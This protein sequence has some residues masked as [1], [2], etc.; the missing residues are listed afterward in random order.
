MEC[1]VLLCDV[2]CLFCVQKLKA[3]HEL[4][5]YLNAVVK[6]SRILAHDENCAGSQNEI[7]MCEEKYVL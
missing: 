6:E 4:L 1:N 7:G 3:Y 2:Y 5:E